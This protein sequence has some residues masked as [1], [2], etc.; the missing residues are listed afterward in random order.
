MV[1]YLEYYTRAIPDNNVAV[2]SLDKKWTQDWFNVFDLYKIAK[3]CYNPTLRIPCISKDFKKAMLAKF[4]VSKI[5]V[6]NNIV[7][8]RIVVFYNEN[9][10]LDKNNEKLKEVETDEGYDYFL[11]I[12][13]PI[14]QLKQLNQ[15]QQKALDYIY[16]T[17][18]NCIRQNIQ[19]DI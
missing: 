3:I 14:A 8:L 16:S 5:L 11:T 4:Y 6:Q 2:L 12:D 18:T 10:W 15:Q 13:V 19:T 17:F 7:K 1:H 9:K